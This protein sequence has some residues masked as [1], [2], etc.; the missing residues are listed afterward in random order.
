M[1]DDK[2]FADTNILIYAYDL[3]AGEK[4]KIAKG[5]V[6]DLWDSGLGLL[7]TQVLQEFFVT[8]TQ[9]IPKPLNVKAAQGIVRDFLKWDVVVNNGESILEAIEIQKQHG[10][11]FW[12]S[13]IIEAAI[14]GGAAIL[15]TEDLSHGQVINDL[16]IKNPF[17]G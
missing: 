4:H 1:P 17:L 5:I 6:M 2:V 7:S 16:K 14:R 10:F 8:V 15:L 9:K 13:M 12:D 11:S 3:S